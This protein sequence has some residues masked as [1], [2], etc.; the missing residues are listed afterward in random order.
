MEASFY[1]ACSASALTDSNNLALQQ[2]SQ[3]S[4]AVAEAAAANGLPEPEKS[5]A[6]FRADL[7]TST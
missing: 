3:P 1:T 5:F 6:D 2:L 7:Y 4:S